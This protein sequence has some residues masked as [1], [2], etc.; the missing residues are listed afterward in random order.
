MVD[1]DDRQ[2]NFLEKTMKNEKEKKE[3]RSSSACLKDSRESTLAIFLG[4]RPK[5]RPRLL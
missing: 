2:L 3:K 5:E 4:G 1:N